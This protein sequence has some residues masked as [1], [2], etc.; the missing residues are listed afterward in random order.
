[1]D[2]EE[3]IVEFLFTF[4]F[5]QYIYDILLLLSIALNRRVTEPMVFPYSYSR[6]LPYPLFLKRAFK[7][8]GSI[9]LGVCYVCSRYLKYT[10]F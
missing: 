4:I 7:P 8:S 1:M 6:Y 3:K 5:T 2:L 10:L 9:G